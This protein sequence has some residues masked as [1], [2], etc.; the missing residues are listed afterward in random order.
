[1]SWLVFQIAVS[2]SAAPREPAEVSG[3]PCVSLEF[4]SAASPA[5]RA[6]WVAGLG[7]GAGTG[8]TASTTL[9]AGFFRQTSPWRQVL[10]TLLFCSL[11]GVSGCARGEWHT[12]ARICSSLSSVFWLNQQHSFLG[13]VSSFF[14]F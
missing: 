5:Q 11:L 6:P 2:G 4:W 7:L 14:P 10:C 12:P 13:C 1:M 9:T 3:D 8:A